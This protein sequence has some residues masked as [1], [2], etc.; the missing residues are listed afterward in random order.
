MFII[1]CSRSILLTMTKHLLFLTGLVL[2]SAMPM[3]HGM[4]PVAGSP[5]ATSPVSSP[6]DVRTVQTVTTTSAQVPVAV[7]PTSPFQT[8]TTTSAQVPVAVVTTSPP[9]AAPVTVLPVFSPST[10]GPVTASPVT[11]SPVT[12]SPVTASPVTASPVTE[13]MSITATLSQPT[14][15]PATYVPIS[16]PLTAPLSSAPAAFPSSAVPIPDLAPPGQVGYPST[17]PSAA[18]SGETPA[19]SPLSSPAE[20]PVDIATVTCN[21]YDAFP[22]YVDAAYGKQT[23]AW[24]RNVGTGVAFNVLCSSKTPLGYGFVICPKTCGRC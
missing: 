24:L 6:V 1:D 3:A 20:S 4:S 2:A 17:F 12:A 13:T 16:P 5:S 19:F 23:C 21:D 18:P 7:V 9:I 14:W 22:F 8:V 15:M 11:A 10:S